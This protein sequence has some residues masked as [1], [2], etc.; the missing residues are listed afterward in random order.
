MVDCFNV[1]VFLLG[2]FG[3]FAYIMSM[4]LQKN[5][6]AGA[7]RVDIMCG[8]LYGF[9]I[10][11][12][13]IILFI[14]SYTM[15]DYESRVWTEFMMATWFIFQLTVP[16]AAFILQIL[17]QI[18][19][20]HDTP[21]GTVVFF[22]M[23]A[24]IFLALDLFLL[25][26]FYMSGVLSKLLRLMYRWDRLVKKQSLLYGSPLESPIDSPEALAWYKRQ[27]A[28][29]R[30]QASLFELKLLS[31][32]FT[33]K[34]EPSS[35]NRTQTCYICDG[36]I[37]QNEKIFFVENCNEM[38][39]WTCYEKLLCTTSHCSC[40]GQPPFQMFN[41]GKLR[42]ILNASKQPSDVRSHAESLKNSK[43][44]LLNQN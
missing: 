44:E 13:P 37:K 7:P 20:G 23:F 11:A 41:I 25:L 3:I 43:L 40:R 16:F 31:H 38:H 27:E 19:S 6:P 15:R 26:I 17:F 30:A 18:N 12:L 35:R 32:Y 14:E 9:A 22:W 24:S 4:C 28:Y 8:N 21:S 33:W 34:Y 36:L 5:L 29:H 10:I 2:S 42:T 1:S 39:H